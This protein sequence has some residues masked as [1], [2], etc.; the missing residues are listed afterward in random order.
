MKDVL[1]QTKTSFVCVGTAYEVSLEEKVNSNGD[2]CIMGSIIAISFTSPA[3]T[4]VSY[5]I[6]TMLLSLHTTGTL[7]SMV[8]VANPPVLC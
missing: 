6:Y 4:L 8:M 2:E 7:K 5:I 1:N 3:R